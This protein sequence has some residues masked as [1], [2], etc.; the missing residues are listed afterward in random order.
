[1]GGSARL[2]AIS[3]IVAL[4][5][6]AAAATLEEV[7]LPP[8]PDMVATAL[9]G[10]YE[11]WR[12]PIRVDREG[13]DF[14]RHKPQPGEA[15]PAL[16]HPYL[17]SGDFDGDGR[18]DYAVYLMRP[19]GAQTSHVTVVALADGRVVKLEGPD[20]LPDREALYFLD[21]T[22]KGSKLTS[23]YSAKTTRTATDAVDLIRCEAASKSFVYDSRRKRFRAVQTSD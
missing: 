21:V 8:L 10:P 18:A 11:G 9:A 1:M 6:S 20:T 12:I 23:V 4:A 7:A 3:L 5:A 15:P 22:P 2:G 13:Y 16:R 17:V 14:C 19:H